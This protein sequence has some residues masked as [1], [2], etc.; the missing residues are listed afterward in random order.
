VDEQS[1]VLAELSDKMDTDIK[2]SEERCSKVLPLAFNVYKD[3][4][5]SHYNTQ[6]HE[7]RVRKCELI[8]IKLIFPSKM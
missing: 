1:L 5:P 6:F 8:K 7:T 2:F 3:N 4:L